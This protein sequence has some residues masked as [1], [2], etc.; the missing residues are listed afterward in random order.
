MLQFE[1]FRYQVSGIRNSSRLVSASPTATVSPAAT[2]VTTA[3][4]EPATA[5]SAVIVMAAVGESTVVAARGL[6]A[7]ASPT[8]TAGA[9]DDA[10]YHYYSDYDHNSQDRTHWNSPFTRFSPGSGSSLPAGALWLQLIR[11]VRGL[12]GFQTRPY[13]PGRARRHAGSPDTC[14]PCALTG[15][16]SSGGSQTA[17]TPFAG[18]SPCGAGNCGRALMRVRAG[19]ILYGILEETIC[20]GAWSGSEDDRCDGR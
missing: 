2:S 12:G 18:M 9:K 15:R 17:P 8:T 11:A 16:S 14:T 3:A 6:T 13:V 7:V 5:L 10:C 20:R 4:V 19:R 1:G